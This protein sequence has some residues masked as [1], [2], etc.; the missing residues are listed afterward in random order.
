MNTNLKIDQLFDQ[1]FDIDT[2]GVPVFKQYI[3]GKWSNASTGKTLNVYT[4]INGEIIAHV[5]SSNKKDVNNAVETAYKARNRIRDMPAIQRIGLFHKARDLIRQHKAS[6]AQAIMLEAGKP[7]H[8]AEGETKAAADRMEFVMQEA[9]KIFGEYLPGDWAEDASSKVGL[10]ILEPLGVVAAISPFNYPLFI[11]AA[12]AV[13]ALLAGNTV[14]AKAASDT[15]IALL[16]LARVFEEAGVPSGAFNVVTGRGGEMGDALVT[17]PYVRGITFTGSTEVG[18]HLASLANVRKQ[19]FELGGKGM[20]LVMDDADIE[21]AANKCVHGSLGNAGQRCDAISAIL[22]A[23]S[24]ADEFSKHIVDE[25]KEWKLGDPMDHATKVVPVINMAAAE[26]IQ[27]LVD[28]AVEKGASLLLGGKHSDCYFEPTVLD[29][30]PLDAD[31][32]HEEIFGPVLTIIRV[33]DEDTAL[34][35][36]NDTPYG[37]DSCVFSESFYRIWK[38]AKKLQV[39]GVAVNDFPRHGVGFFPFGGW[40]D[41]G[42]GREG[43]GY[44]IEEMTSLKTITFNLEPA[45]LGKKWQEFP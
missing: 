16:M 1:I 34:E 30:V 33:P 41:S 22:V 31:I 38:I 24:V 12:K 19:H 26:R 42:V 25:V 29:N 5:Q 27:A 3:G 32:A 14:V 2:D 6:F 43:I 21:L 35:I 23:E 45:K 40:K 13:P 44:S 37:L 15:P 9:R 36:A 18:K 11:A 8:H 39:G 10:V 17:H 7:L 28:D 4:P 20:A